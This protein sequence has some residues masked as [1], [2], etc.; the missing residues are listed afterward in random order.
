MIDPQI[1]QELYDDL[2][3]KERREQRE[4]ADLWW[5]GLSEEQKYAV[6]TFF[7]AILRPTRYSE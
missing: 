3:K 2:K 5:S 4:A 1:V 6:F 7:N